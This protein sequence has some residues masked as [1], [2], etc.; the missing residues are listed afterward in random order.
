MKHVNNGSGFSTIYGDQITQAMRVIVNQVENFCWGLLYKGAS[1]S[2]GT[3]GT[4]PFAT[5]FNGVSEIRQILVDNGMPD[6]GRTT[7]VINTLAGTKMR[8]LAQL[9][10]VNTSGDSQLLRQGTL[11]DLHR[12]MIKE[13]AAPIVVAKGTG[14]S[15]TSTNAGFPVGTTSIPLITGTGT[16]LAGDRVTFAGDANIYVVQTGVAAPGTI[17]LNEP[18]LRQ[19]I[20]AA[21]TAMTV[22]N[23]A[24]M[25]VAVHQ[26][27]FELAIRPMELPNGSDAAVDVMNIQDPH[28]GLSFQISA[29]KGY[30][31]AMFEVSTVYGAKAWKP[32]FIAALLG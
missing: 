13:S 12:L 17:T 29:Y 10:Q 16:V 22:G 28:S 3:A 4:N 18:G 32:D 30:K 31:K 5:N 1:R 7:L 23:N 21:A 27:A 19:A 14:A 9:Q 11:L 8:Q 2:F 25:N 26:S 15:Y 24:T 6:D 20:P